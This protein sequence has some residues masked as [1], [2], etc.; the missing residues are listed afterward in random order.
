M[1][2]LLNTLFSEVT[3]QWGGWVCFA[4]YVWLANKDKNESHK[5]S[6]EALL[7]NAEALQRLTVLFQE[8]VK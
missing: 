7:K 1:E 8:R 6:T 4:G 3:I 2:S 5:A